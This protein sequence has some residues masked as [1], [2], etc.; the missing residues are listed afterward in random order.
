MWGDFGY[1]S[2]Y[3]VPAWHLAAAL[4]TQE[5]KTMPSGDEDLYYIPDT[6]RVT[7]SPSRRRHKARH[8]PKS[9]QGPGP[10]EAQEGG[11]QAHEGGQQAAAAGRKR[12]GAGKAREL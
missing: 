2:P 12:C 7:C 9:G 6:I 8:R 11:Q 5:L 1:V 10:G 4:N 3:E